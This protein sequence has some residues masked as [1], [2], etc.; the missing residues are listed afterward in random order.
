MIKRDLALND[1]FNV[2][3]GGGC[4]CKEECKKV[5][6]IM[7]I[8]QTGVGKTTLIDSFA[9]HLLGI[10]LFDQFRYKLVDERSLIEQRVPRN[11]R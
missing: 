9:N 7:V 1:P 3:Y 5:M 11:G 10:E 2:L 6:N 4:S 8:G